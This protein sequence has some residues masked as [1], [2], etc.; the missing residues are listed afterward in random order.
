MGLFGK[1]YKCDAC[2]TKFKKEEDLMQH[3]KQAHGKKDYQC[4]TCN[5]AFRSEQ[6]LM[7]HGKQAH[8]M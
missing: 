4:K 8:N 1:K 6:E 7:Q 3:A 2:G 5:M